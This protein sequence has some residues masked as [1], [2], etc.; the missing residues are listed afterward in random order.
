[1][2]IIQSCLVM[3]LVTLFTPFALAQDDLS[4]TFLTPNEAFSMNYP[5][6]WEASLLDTAVYLFSSSPDISFDNAITEVPSG[7]LIGVVVLPES[8]AGLG[9]EQNTAP[10]D[11]LEPIKGF[12]F[13]KDTVTEIEDIII[14][15]FPA[16]RINDDKPSYSQ[17]LAISI[18][19]D[20]G[21]VLF[22]GF[23]A[24][25]ELPE[26]EAT[27]I[28]I[29]ESMS[30][31]AVDAPDITTIV[32]I[33]AD[34]A[35]STQ[36]LWNV[37]DDNIDIQAGALSPDGE[38][39][40][41]HDVQNDVLQFIDTATGETFLE[42]VEEEYPEFLLFT[43][44]GYQLVIVYDNGTVNYIDSVSGDVAK[45]LT[46]EMPLAYS[47]DGTFAVHFVADIETRDLKL[48][49]IEDEVVASEL[50]LED[51]FSSEPALSADG[52]VLAFPIDKDVY[53]VNT[54]NPEVGEPFASVEGEDWNQITVVGL[55]P[56]GSKLAF[57]DDEYK[58][59][60]YDIASSELLYTIDR[61][62][63]YLN[64]DYLVFSP[65]GSVLYTTEYATI[66]LYDAATGELLA[67]LPHNVEGRM[68]MFDISA[69][70]RLLVGA[71]YGGII[72][73]GVPD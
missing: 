3:I 52:S 41:L 18:A 57:A 11:V 4:E 17:T 32:P 14:N 65:D 68:A 15:G 28:S 49:F 66:Q 44:D 53:V 55:S 71:S 47:S 43:P 62:E 21:T 45:T 26:N 30:M 8:L 9:L 33:T 37:L 61:T 19:F 63:D 39:M 23:T 70:G 5:S 34:N 40:A 16:A 64:L 59:Y 22:L 25:G 20:G 7:E 46:F 48:T 2:R 51:M 72:L 69:D 56:D 50:E 67:S 29:V 10:T 12:F 36:M 42:V 58:G 73:W 60:I 35:G 6:G 1:M 54:S 38:L 13:D 27:F 31:V 24:P